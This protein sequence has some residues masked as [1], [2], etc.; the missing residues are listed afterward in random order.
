MCLVNLETLVSLISLVCVF[1]EF[2]LYVLVNLVT[3][4][5][6]ISLVCVFSEFILCVSIR[7]NVMLAKVSLKY[8]SMSAIVLLVLFACF[9]NLPVSGRCCRN[10]L[11]IKLFI[12]L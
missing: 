8:V 6:L 7:H 5:S 3:L 12:F 2:I 10:F 1:S 9:G 11:L 4:V